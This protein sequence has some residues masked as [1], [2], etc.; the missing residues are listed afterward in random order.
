MALAAEVLAEWREAERVLKVLPEDAPER[1]AAAAAVEEM[2]QL[3]Q[4]VAI[5]LATATTSAIAQT[6]ARIEA[7]HALVLRIQARR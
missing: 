2:R 3:Y 4:Y 5:D 6:R 7:T 1:P